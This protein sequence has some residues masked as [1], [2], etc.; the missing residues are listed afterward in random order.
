[1]TAKAPVFCNSGVLGFRLFKLLDEFFV[2]VPAESCPFILEVEGELRGMGEMTILAGFLCRLVNELFFKTFSFFL[3]TIKT[4]GNPVKFQKELI[5][6]G[7]RVVTYNA[8]STGHRT[9]NILLG[10]H[11]IFM[12]VK[13]EYRK[14]LFRE[15]EFVVRLVG[16]MTDYTLTFLNR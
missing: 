1:M 16:I 8:V 12:A 3:V 9:V 7:M 6:R 13:A 11:V 10:R 15:K 4:E 5:F 2:T 14:G